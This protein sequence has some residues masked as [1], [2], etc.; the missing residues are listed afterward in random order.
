MLRI[1][2][3]FWSALL[4]CGTLGCMAP[5]NEKS[6]GNTGK[7]DTVPVI[8]HISS[9]I[10]SMA[11]NFSGQSSF[12]FDSS[13]IKVF[14]A[15][16]TDFKPL[17]SD[18]RRF[19]RQRNYAYAWYEQGNLI[20]QATGLYARILRIDEEG[21]PQPLP[22]SNTLRAMMEQHD[23]ISPIPANP[24]A[25]LLLTAQYLYFARKVWQGIGDNNANETDW[26]LPRKKLTIA[27]LMELL[28][29]E[30]SEMPRDTLAVYMQYE[31]L[32]KYLKKYR[33]IET[34]GGW[35]S[36]SKKGMPYRI[37]DTSAAITQIRKLLYLTEDFR[38]DTLS[39]V[40]DSV[41]S[42]AVKRYQQRHGWAPDGIIGSNTL[43][44]MNVPVGERIRQLLVNME[45]CRW[46]PL[47]M[48]EDYILVNIPAYT[49]EVFE[50]DTI[51]K[52]MR[53][54][55]GKTMNRTVVFT[56][57]LNNIVFNPYWYI[58][59]GIY[60]KEILPEIKKDSGYL[61]KNEMEWFGNNL[62]Q[63]PGL[64]NPLGQIKFVFPNSHNIYLHD[65]PSKGLFEKEQRAFSHGCIRIEEP[66][67]LCNYLL[68]TDTTWNNEKMERIIRSGKEHFIQVK[69]KI[70]VYVIYFTSWVDG[71]GDLQFRKDIY[72]KDERLASMIFEPK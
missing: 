2:Q 70:S 50:N 72:Q 64:N 11:G 31:S 57:R 66:R 39:E 28:L 24:T 10:R 42:I 46:I 36:I 55:V 27:Q 54:V 12:I 17:E 45:R 18:I 26:F 15:R 58:P 19:Y 69:N 32:K 25:E 22:Y 41:F 7:S 61:R 62:R 44:E 14:L 52:T 33:A 49:L 60:R 9:D 1:T 63:K 6:A 16:F 38:G 8:Q 29:K 68:R 37:G 65:T 67:W 71:K 3:F 34:L 4:S 30:K 20:E 40:Y 48:K 21:I 13:A 23:S 5:V 43:Q 56:G 47:S 53:V 35:P 51:V 59:P